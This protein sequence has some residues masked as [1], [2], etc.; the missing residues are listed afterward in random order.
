MNRIIRWTVGSAYALFVA[1]ALT[2][3]AT[4]AF[5]TTTLDDC[6]Q[7]A[8]FI[9]TCPPYED[10]TCAEACSEI[11]GGGGNCFPGGCCICML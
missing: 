8:G 6:T 10:H 4:Q 2:F 9:G 3:G 1:F 5:A 7:E 11:Y